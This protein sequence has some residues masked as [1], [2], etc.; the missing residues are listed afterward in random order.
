MDAHLRRSLSA[1]V[2]AA[3]SIR[4]ISV[5]EVIVMVPTPSMAVIM[6]AISLMDDNSAIIRIM[7][8]NR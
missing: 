8:V 5:S 4:A 1:P 3:V 2:S 7:S 6:V